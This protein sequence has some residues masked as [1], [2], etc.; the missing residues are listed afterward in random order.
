MAG[1]G[2]GVWMAYA[3]PISEQTYLNPSQSERR[4][5][6]FLGA[7]PADVTLA[8]TPCVLDNV[9]LF[10]KR[11]VLFSCEQPSDDTEL[12]SRA[13]A[14]YYADDEQIIRDFCQSYEID[15]LVIDLDTYSDEYLSAGHLFFEPYNQ[16]LL[17]VVKS[18]ESFVLQQ[19]PDDAMVF[20]EENLY[21]V[22]CNEQVFSGQ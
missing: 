22:P 3:L 13:L 15:Y 8:G 17:P 5:L 19:V 12:T 21:V 10:A 11:Q 18:R 7:L 4:L 20:R 6:K 14:T 1:I 2:I 9:P 16:E